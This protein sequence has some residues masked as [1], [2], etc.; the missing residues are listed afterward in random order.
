VKV[1]SIS[2]TDFVYWYRQEDAWDLKASAGRHMDLTE[3]LLDEIALEGL[4]GLTIQ[5]ET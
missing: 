3:H 5:G 4:D 2:H 1:D